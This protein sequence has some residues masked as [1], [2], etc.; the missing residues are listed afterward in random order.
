M[1]D[2]AV[3]ALG[4][5]TGLEQLQLVVEGH[6][7]VATIGDLLGFALVELADGEVTFEMTPDAR[8]LNPMGTVHGGVS[9]TLLDSAMACAV[10]SSLAPGYAYTTAQL[11]IHYLRTMKP[12]MGPVRAT[13]TVIHRG[14]TQS[15]AEG[16]LV[17]PDGKLIAH[18]TTTC[19]ILGG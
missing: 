14:R 13:G 17:G 12:G 15:T 2:V 7:A 10:H 9:A 4:R 5:M 6:V 3:E 11:N 16:R 1:T 19:L 18:G 8:M